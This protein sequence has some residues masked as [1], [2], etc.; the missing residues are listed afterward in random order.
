[1]AEIFCGRLV[2]YGCNESCLKSIRGK[3]I[4]IT[5]HPVLVEEIVKVCL[6]VV[7]TSRLFWVLDCTLGSAGHSLALLKAC[8]NLRIL[9]MDRDSEALTRSKILTADFA[10]RIRFKKSKFSDLDMLFSQMDGSSEM[11]DPFFESL[12]LRDK[13]FDF[14]L[15][16]LGISSNQLEDQER[17]FSFWGDGPLDMRMDR[18]SELTAS[19]VL[20]DYEMRDLT[21]VFRKGGVGEQS[22]SLARKILNSRPIENCAHFASICESVFQ[23]YHRKS[24]EGNKKK[25]PATVPFQAVRIEVN[26]ELE[27]LSKFMEVIP[28][29]LASSSRLAMISFHSLED[30]LVTNTMRSWER[31]ENMPR[32]IPVEGKSGLGKLLTKKAIQPT[33]AEIVR[34][35]RSRSARLR[36][37]Q[38]FDN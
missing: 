4:L 7:D 33:A 37:F 11:A 13:R 30:K 23:R 36:V 29:Y 32:G 3:R 17:G 21:R 16:D 26:G 19:G 5:H 2:L 8:D 27:A 15:A 6:E 34:N 9:G 14:V 20:N 10:E 1:M 18:E 22:A 38:I 28:K 12:D 24:K 31:K 35:P 25:H